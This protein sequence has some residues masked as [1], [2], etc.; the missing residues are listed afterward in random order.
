MEGG[1]RVR[2]T[3]NQTVGNPRTI[4]KPCEESLQYGQPDLNPSIKSIEI[5][6]F[7][8]LPLRNT[9]VLVYQPSRLTLTQ[10]AQQLGPLNSMG[11][12]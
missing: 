4:H 1:L 3:P 8:A 10:Q 5:A 6:L 9:L 2:G 11:L 12:K 7:L